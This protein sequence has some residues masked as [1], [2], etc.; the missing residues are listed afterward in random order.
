[1]IKYN[2]SQ[3]KNFYQNRKDLGKTTPK[4]Y[5][6]SMK[7][8]PDLSN[9]RWLHYIYNIVFVIMLLPIIGNKEI[10]IEFLKYFL[11]VLVLR[12]IINVI[13]ILPKDKYCDDENLTINNYIF[14]HCYDKIFSGHFAI[15]VLLGYI[16]YNAGIVSLNTVILFNIINALIILLLRYHYTVDLVVAYLIVTILY[17]NQIKFKITP[18]SYTY[19]LRFYFEIYLLLVI[20]YFS[21]TSL[22]NC[23]TL[24]CILV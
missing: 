16:M 24:L 11:V 6:I 22:Y 18:L 10:A 1:M 23:C 5:D 20:S 3:G 21:C 14:G 7:Y 2:H 13:T 19:L 4:V 17:Q 8:L 15:S 12:Y 9:I